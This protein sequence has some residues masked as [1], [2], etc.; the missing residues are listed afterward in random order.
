LPSNRIK[1]DPRGLA[2]IVLS[3]TAEKHHLRARDYQNSSISCVPPR[4]LRGCGVN[5][6]SSEIVNVTSTIENIVS[7]SSKKSKTHKNNKRRKIPTTTTSSTKQAP[8][9][10]S[11]SSSATT[12]LRSE[13]ELSTAKNEESS[14]TMTDHTTTTTTTSGETSTVKLI[15]FCRMNII[16]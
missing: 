1:I 3:V 12:T 8:T 4:D 15:C 16:A 10:A 5:I 7:K 9:A 2:F 13:G 6:S 14:T 11:T